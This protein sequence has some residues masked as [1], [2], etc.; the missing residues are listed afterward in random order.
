MR[1][2]TQSNMLR[3]AAADITGQVPLMVVSD[4]LT[5]IAETSIVRVVE[6][7]WAAMVQRYGAP[8]GLAV[9]ESS[10][11]VIGYGK[12]GGIELGYSSDLDMV[13]LHAIDDQFAETDG[14]KSIPVEVFYA[15]L[16]QRMIHLFTT[17]T[18]SG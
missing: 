3:V 8:K 10:F 7:A 12:L 17:R 11:V 14:A 5:E 9:G 6:Q 15:R 2:F 1:Q 13:F 4:Y 18:P 16:A